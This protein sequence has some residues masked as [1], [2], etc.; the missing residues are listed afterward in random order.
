VAVQVQV[1]DLG[2][3]NL[4]LTCRI[5]YIMMDSEL[6]LWDLTATFQKSP[7]QSQA[8]QLE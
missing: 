7:T 2:R 5:G 6:R 3:L 8:I 1:E 4:N